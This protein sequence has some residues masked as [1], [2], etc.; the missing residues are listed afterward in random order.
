MNCDNCRTEQKIELE[1]ED[2]MAPSIA[3]QQNHQGAEFLTCYHVSYLVLAS[4]I[5]VYVVTPI[6]SL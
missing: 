2:F 1:D 3:K 5:S 4:H 6:I